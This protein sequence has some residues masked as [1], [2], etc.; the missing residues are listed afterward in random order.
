MTGTVGRIPQG[1]CLFLAYCNTKKF[2]KSLLP[3]G[4]WTNWTLNDMKNVFLRSVL[5]G[6]TLWGC[7][8]GRDTIS[9]VT[10]SHFLSW[11]NLFHF[12]GDQLVFHLGSEL[13]ALN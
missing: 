5:C 13:N 10:Y 4:A 8:G 3:H 2:R 1:D 9:S 11:K 12:P 6:I 7:G